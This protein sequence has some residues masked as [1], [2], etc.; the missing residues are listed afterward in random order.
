MQMETGGKHVNW[1]LGIHRPSKGD[2]EREGQSQRE[3]E[4]FTVKEN[5]FQSR[6]QTL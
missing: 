4:Y 6:P 1:Q 5:H 3:D 2:Y